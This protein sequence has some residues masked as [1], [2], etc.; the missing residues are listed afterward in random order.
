MEC[1]CNFRLLVGPVGQG[2]WYDPDVL[3]LADKGA[4]KQTDEQRGS[5]GI[6]L[7]MFGVLNV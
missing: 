6:G 4:G 5:G 1:L 2:I 7:L 3:R